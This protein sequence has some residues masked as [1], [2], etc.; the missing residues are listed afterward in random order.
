MHDADSLFLEH[1][2]CR[3]AY[4]IRGEGPPVLFIQG[5]G[6]HGNGWYLQTGALAA[7]FRCLSFDNRGLGQSQPLGMPLSVER[8]AEDVEAL[9]DNQ[10]WPSAH[11]VG[12]SLGGVVALHLALVAPGRVR[13]LSLL[14]TVARGRDAT[15]LSWPMLSIGM[16]SSLGTPRLRRRAFLELVMPPDIF[17]HSDRDELAARLEPIFGRDLA[18][19]PPI[20]M[21]QLSA[22]RAYDATPRLADLAKTP[23]L[24]V[25]AGH[26]LIAP[27]RCGRALAAGIPGA[28]YVEFSEASHGLMIQCA[29]EIN[30][31]LHEHLAQAEEKRRA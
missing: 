5:V 28:R 1:G 6:V 9:L 27:P 4:R 14:C 13:S 31:L 22:L 18:R 19:Q 7:H 2:G 17:A 23:T 16:R 25:S 11:L 30:A 20:V 24:V 10:G 8:M 29:D 15:Q 3:L 26:D 12:H 21:K